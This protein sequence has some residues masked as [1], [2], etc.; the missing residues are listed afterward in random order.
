MVIGFPYFPKP[1]SYRKFKYN[2]VELLHE[3][4][5]NIIMLLKKTAF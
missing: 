3:T 5:A 1:R 4:L 2:F